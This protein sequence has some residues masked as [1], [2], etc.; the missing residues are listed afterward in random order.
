MSQSRL[1]TSLRTNVLKRG[2][3]LD[4][5]SKQV[6]LLSWFFKW[7]VLAFFDNFCWK[8]DFPDKKFIISFLLFYF[9]W[10]FLDLPETKC[11]LF[12]LLHNFLTFILLTH[13][14]QQKNVKQAFGWVKVNVVNTL[15]FFSRIHQS[16]HFHQPPRSAQ[17]AQS[18][19]WTK[20]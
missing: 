3:F 14:K 15:L 9:F 2:N 5:E 17:E 8:G 1:L 4:K 6:C 20:L 12:V 11:F 16:L 13:Y 7:N 18:H 19:N 10:R